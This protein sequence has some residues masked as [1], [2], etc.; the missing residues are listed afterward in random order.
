MNN[1]TLL[2]NPRSANSKHR[3][4]NSILQ[5]GASIYGRHDFV[6]VDGNL[7]RDPW[8]T[9]AAPPAHRRVPLF[10]LH[11]DAG[12]ATAPS[13]PLR[14]ARPGGV[15]AGRQHLGRLFCQQPVARGARKRL[16]GF[17]GLW[18]R[19]PHV[20][21]PARRARKR[22]P[23]RVHPQPH[24]ENPRRRPHQK[25]QREPARPRRAAHLALRFPRPAL[26]ALALLE[27]YFFRKKNAG[28]PQQH[29]LPLQVLVLC[30]GA[31]FRG[32]LARQIGGRHFSR[33]P[34]CAPALGSR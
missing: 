31:H 17:R 7:E 22:H 4:P 30:G 26:P 9:I 33:H 29:G 34:V 6:F 18:P 27:P 2:F 5:V 3:V 15:S 23:L 24:L 12:A 28:L 13:H 14:A 25:H 11:R 16:R 10:R 19:R 32:P 8:A 20:P 1:R 21:G